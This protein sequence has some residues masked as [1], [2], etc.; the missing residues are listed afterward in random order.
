MV[1]AFDVDPN[2]LIGAAAEKLKGMNIKEPSYIPFVKSGS[3]R[4][5]RPTQDD[6][7]YLRCA[8]VLRQAYTKGRIGV[9]SLRT[10]FGSRLKRGVKPEKHRKS[11]GSIIRDAFIELE[12][13]GL[14]EKKKD[15]RHIS[16]KGRSLLDSVAKEVSKGS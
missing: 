8:A 9:S 12:K 4:Q 13:A 2:R 1:T 15:G 7:W 11:G 5:R 14:L 16:A 10:H 3:D 6:F